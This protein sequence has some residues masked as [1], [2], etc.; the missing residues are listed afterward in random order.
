MKFDGGYEEIKIDPQFNTT[1]IVTNDVE[2]RGERGRAGYSWHGIQSQ[3]L[4]V[5]N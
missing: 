1:L 4:F 3:G 5:E 2:R